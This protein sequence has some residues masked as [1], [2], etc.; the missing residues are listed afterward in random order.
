[1]SPNSLLLRNESPE[2]VSGPARAVI[3]LE[4]YRENLRRLRSFAPKSQQMAIVKAGAYGH[5]LTEMSLA[6]I[7][8]GAEW[9]GVAQASEAYRL[10]RELDRAG[11][12]HDQLRPGATTSALSGRRYQNAPV[13]L[14]SARRPRI[15]S[16]IYGPSTDLKA[17]LSADI[18]LSASTP[19][20]LEQI[21]AAADA[22]GVRARVHLKVDTGMARGGCLPEDFAQLVAAAHAKVRTGLLEVN[23][24][25]SHF[26]RAD[27]P[28][29]EGEAYTARQ[30][31]LLQQA[32]DQAWEG[33]LEPHIRHIAASGGILWYPESHLEI[34]RPG[35]AAYG[36]SP[37]PNVATSGDL[38]LH[39][40]M[41]LEAEVV[42]VKLLPAG[43][44]A[45]YGSTWTAPEDTWLALVPVGY[46]DG[47]PR[48]ASNTAP[49]WVSGRRG[50]VVGRVCMD[51]IIVSLGPARDAQGNL[52]PAPAAPG[53]L[54]V[55]WG[56]PADRLAATVEPLTP[57]PFTH[58]ASANRRL[59]ELHEQIANP[60]DPGY[61]LL[62]A[63][64]EWAVAA[65]TISYELFTQLAPSVERH[66]L[67]PLSESAPPATR[68]P[69]FNL[70]GGA[71]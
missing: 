11:I 20:Q 71:R 3:N 69:R 30:L 64:T 32:F 67:P 58:G 61:D 66:Y 5:G 10:R 55:L 63:V 31:Q 38:G 13:A 4:A 48:S 54:A 37:N 46:G 18:D 70:P 53:D 24:V 42:Q 21:A 36:L 33:G 23:A 27:E 17:V 51:Q 57:A 9:L 14:P 16:W 43:E 7:D 28:T 8:S 39:P 44:S 34:V 41:R 52:L 45:S 25:W 35:I 2:T 50:R 60:T 19:A 65:Q 22:A 56:D 12:P 15:F 62:P 49:V 6:A 59:A 1:M 47:L 26:A 40:V 29:A 68:R